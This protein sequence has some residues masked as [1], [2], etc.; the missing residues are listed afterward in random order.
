MHAYIPTYP[1]IHLPAHLPILVTKTLELLVTEATTRILAE[2]T[3]TDIPNPSE[4]YAHHHYCTPT[5]THV[6]SHH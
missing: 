5:P 4:V 3:C 2:L 6:L 1:P